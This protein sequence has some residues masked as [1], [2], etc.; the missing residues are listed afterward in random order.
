M[1]NDWQDSVR[2]SIL[3][4]LKMSDEDLKM[5]GIQRTCEALISTMDAQFQK[6]EG[7]SDAEMEE[8][9]SS[10]ETIK[11]LLRPRS[12]RRYDNPCM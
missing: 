9:K 1:P 7:L 12:I 5:W 11:H 2:N 3:D 10:Y 4:F 8:V 6:Q